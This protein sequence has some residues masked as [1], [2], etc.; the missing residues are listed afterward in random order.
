MK[1][2]VSE[3]CYNEISVLL[4]RQGREINDGQA[5]QIEKGTAIMPP[6]DFRMVA[7]RQNCLMAATEVYKCDQSCDFLYIAQ[8]IFDWALNGTKPNQN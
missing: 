4:K 3:Q 6:Y 7:V 1:L 5:I 8:Q 2:E